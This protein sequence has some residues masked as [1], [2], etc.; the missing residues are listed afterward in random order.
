MSTKARIQTR[1]KR[2]KRYVFTRGDFKDLAVTIRL[3]GRYANW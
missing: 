3:A 1:L 2:S